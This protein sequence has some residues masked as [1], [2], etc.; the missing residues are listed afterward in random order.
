ML[1][2]KNVVACPLRFQASLISTS[3]LCMSSPHVFPAASHYKI[4]RHK[5]H[6]HNAAPP[7]CTSSLHRALRLLVTPLARPTLFC[8]LSP[9]RT[10]VLLLW[11]LLVSIAMPPSLPPSPWLL[12]FLAVTAVVTAVFGCLAVFGRS[13]EGPGQRQ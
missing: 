3:A 9:P 11:W 6:D 12:L 4:I 5:A 10:L 13:S 2:R 8:L 1:F 7:R